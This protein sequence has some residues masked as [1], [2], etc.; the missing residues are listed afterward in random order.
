[1]V[2]YRDQPYLTTVRKTKQGV[3]NGDMVI[4][5]MIP[6]LTTVDNLKKKKK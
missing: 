2:I 4:G 5:H 6:Y 3:Q 1:M